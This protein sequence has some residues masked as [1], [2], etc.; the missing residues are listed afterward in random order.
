MNTPLSRLRE[1]VRE[2]LDAGESQAALAKRLRL[3]QPT[4]SGWLTEDE[5][6][7]KA[8][9]LAVVVRVLGVNGHWLLS[10]EG[11]RWSLSVG[12]DA[13]YREGRRAGLREAARE[14]ERLAATSPGAGGSA[15]EVMRLARL[16]EQADV[17]AARPARPKRHPSRGA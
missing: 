14:A 2:A 17:P 16:G 1:V 10:G 5:L 9:V 12:A 4:I 3:S 13:L 7:P 11:E 8:S 15:E 6:D